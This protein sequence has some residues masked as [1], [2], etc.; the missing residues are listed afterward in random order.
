ME[1][2]S[3]SNLNGTKA[4]A[5]LC[6]SCC[7]EFVEVEFDFELEGVV[8]HNVKALRCPSCKE[9]LFTPQQIETIKKRISNPS[10]P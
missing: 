7:V 8:L 2:N 5:L 10:E 6:P 1:K 4:N 3:P 9:E